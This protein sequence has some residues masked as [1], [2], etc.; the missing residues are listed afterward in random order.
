MQT[1]W[2]VQENIQELINYNICI[3]RIVWIIGIFV[4]E[5]NIRVLES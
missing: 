3:E 2:R 5:N 1:S 4:Q